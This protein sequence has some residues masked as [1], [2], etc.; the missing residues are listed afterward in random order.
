M[1]H[2]QIENDDITSS[3]VGQ[4]L[5]VQQ[6][7]QETQGLLLT[8]KLDGDLSSNPFLMS[9]RQSS[10]TQSFVTQ[11]LTVQQRVKETQSLLSWYQANGSDSELNSD[12]DNS[13]LAGEHMTELQMQIQE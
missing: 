7:V 2:T 13:T 10:I 5:A 3:F 11:R 12:F 4:R 6:R 8:N 1:S 9:H